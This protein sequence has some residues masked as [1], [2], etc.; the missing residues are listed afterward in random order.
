MHFAGVTNGRHFETVLKSGDCSLADMIRA[1]CY[2]TPFTDCFLRN[3]KEFEHM[4][5]V[6]C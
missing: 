2:N 3:L 1:V 4:L 6:Q 5:I